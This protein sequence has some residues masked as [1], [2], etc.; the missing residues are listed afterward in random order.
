MPITRGADPTQVI[1]DEVLEVRDQR[2][3]VRIPVANELLTNPA[4]RGTV[5]NHMLHTAVRQAR[6]SANNLLPPGAPVVTHDDVL[7]A[8]MASDTYRE[9]RGLPPAPRRNVV[10]AG[11]VIPAHRGEW[12]TARGIYQQG[13]VEPHDIRVT[14]DVRDNMPRLRHLLQA[15]PADTRPIRFEALDELDEPDEHG[16]DELMPLTAKRHCA[17]GDHASPAWEHGQI[18]CTYRLDRPVSDYED[19]GPHDDEDD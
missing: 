3:A 4:G 6:M 15:A 13:W 18:E 17:C 9:L 2:I 10:A 16:L 19:D 8:L 12:A 11:G 14:L 7:R 5:A 1:I